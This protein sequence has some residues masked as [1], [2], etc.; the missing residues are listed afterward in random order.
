MIIRKTIVQKGMA[1]EHTYGYH[2]PLFS[3]LLKRKR[4]G[5]KENE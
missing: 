1:F 3:S 4:E 2:F 5:E